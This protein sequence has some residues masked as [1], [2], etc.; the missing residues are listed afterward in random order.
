MQFALHKVHFKSRP[1]AEAIYWRQY[2]KQ[3]G[4]IGSWF[5]GRSSYLFEDLG[6]QGLAE[7]RRVAVGR[8]RPNWNVRA[9][10]NTGSRLL[11]GAYREKWRRSGSGSECKLHENML[12]T[13]S[14]TYIH[15]LFMANNIKYVSDLQ[16]NRSGPC[17]SSGCARNRRGSGT[18][19]R[20]TR[21]KHCI[22]ISV[23]FGV[24]RSW[25]SAL[26]KRC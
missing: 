1:M 25:F 18:K 17:W 12:T 21:Y 2:P 26:V 19:N 8:W 9:L 23:T 5:Q 20:L 10:V 16:F 7:L 11:R 15:L 6:W 24:R 3:W 13:Y 14:L 22:K 4:K